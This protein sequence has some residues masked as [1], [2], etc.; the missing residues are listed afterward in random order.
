MTHRHYPIMTKCLFCQPL[1]GARSAEVPHNLRTAASEKNPAHSSRIKYFSSGAVPSGAC[2]ASRNRGPREKKF[3]SGKIRKNQY[4]RTPAKGPCRTINANNRL[5]DS[6]RSFHV[7]WING[8]VGNDIAA[9]VL[10]TVGVDSLNL[11]FGSLTGSSVF[12]HMEVGR[13]V[14]SA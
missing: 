2:E 5:E 3:S 14:R 9:G 10:V 6:Q 1:D 11:D 12:P 7:F 13:L 4:G 8:T